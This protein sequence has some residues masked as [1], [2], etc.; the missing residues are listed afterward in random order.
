MKKLIKSN[1]YL[2]FIARKIYST[3]PYNKRKLDKYFY[4]FTALLKENEKKSLD[5]VKE[6]QFKKL[7]DIINKAYYYT[8][9]YRQKYDKVGFKPD[10]LQTLADISKIPLLTKDEVRKYGKDMVDKR[11]DIKKLYKGYT[12][13]TTGKALELFFD[14]KTASRE[15]A[16]ICY[17]WERVGYKA[18]DGRIELR[19]FI[20]DDNDFVFL[21]DERVLRINIIKM[22]SVNIEKI[23]NKIQQL[24]Y[25]FIHGYPS[26]IY[27][28]A[29]ILKNNNIVYEPKAIMMASEI[30]YDWQM[31]VI[32]EVFDCP[33]IIHYGQA[34]KVALG[35]WTSERKY[36]FI[37]SYGI[38]EFDEDSK[39]LIATSLIN[40]VMPFI[41]YKLTDTAIGVSYKPTNKNYT[42]YPVI[43]NIVGRM[44]D[45]TYDCYGNLIPPAVATFPF[46]QLKYID[47]AKIIQEGIKTFDLILETQLEGNDLNLKKEIEILISNMKKI[48]GSEAIINIVLTKSIKKDLS[49]KFRWI[50]C[51]INRNL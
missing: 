42:L 39:E 11:I 34:E 4:E 46:K 45:Y 3:I 41:R 44:E 7:K 6:Y 25:K 38:V 26:A 23:V 22:N 40:E 9:F 32:D 13:G 43:E 47:A 21:P 2:E 20:Q 10:D 15:F 16:S 31:Q 37:P 17:Q 36:S 1:K 33:K 8:D 48:Y 5:E 14:K 18:G 28:F 35:A 19:G 49:G 27:K 24:G 12:S 29:K 30:L 51:K 50:E